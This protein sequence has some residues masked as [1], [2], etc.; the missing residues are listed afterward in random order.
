[1]WC[2]LFFDK[3]VTHQASRQHFWGINCKDPCKGKLTINHV[4][5]KAQYEPVIELATCIIQNRSRALILG[6]VVG[7]T[8]NGADPELP[9]LRN[10]ITQNTFIQQRQKKEK[11]K[12]SSSI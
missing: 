10:N 9:Q 1:M 6:F 12:K 4:R 11:A 5:I 3:D 8:N 2:V 7:S